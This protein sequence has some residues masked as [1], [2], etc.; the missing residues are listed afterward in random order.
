MKFQKQRFM[1]R[2]DEGVY[3]D[4]L[5]TCFAILLGVEAEEVPHFMSSGEFDALQY[6]DWLEAAG[7]HLIRVQIPGDTAIESVMFTANAMGMGLPY[8]LS[9]WSRTPSN[10]CVI[11]HGTEIVCDPSLTDSGIVG[12]MHNED[13]T[14]TWWIEWLVR[15]L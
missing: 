4:C 11:A 1:H 15:P 9:G 2:P 3:G 13:G 14:F 12:P 8:I 6:D 5:R 7:L 10:H